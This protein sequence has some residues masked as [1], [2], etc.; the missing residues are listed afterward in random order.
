MSITH[1]LADLSSIY[2]IRLETE[3]WAICGSRL[4]W[5]LSQEM[6]Q[7]DN[8]GRSERYAWLKLVHAIVRACKGKIGIG[9]VKLVQQNA[10]VRVIACSALTAKIRQP[11]SFRATVK[12]AVLSR[13]RSSISACPR[14]LSSGSD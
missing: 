13:A 4:I 3:R 2:V 5:L 6:E 7:N 8:S 9:I 11:F 10:T 12:T 14:L 1:P